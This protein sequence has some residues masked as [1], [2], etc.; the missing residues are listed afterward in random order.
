MRKKMNCMFSIVLLL[1]NMLPFL[2]LSAR[3]DDLKIGVA[4]VKITPPLGIPLAGQYFD[5]GATAVHDDLF[6]KALVIET[7]G[8]KVAIVT[9]D[10]VDIGTDLVPAVRKMA[11]KSTGIPGDHIMISATHSHTG[12]VIPSPGNINSSQGPIPDILTAYIEKLP[13]LICESIKQ[14]NKNLRS[15]R[16]SGGLGHE[17]TISF[18]RRFY[19]TDGTVGWNPGKLNP[20]IIKPAGPIDPDVSVLYAETFDGTPLLTFVNFALHLDIAGGL[21]ISADMPYTLSKILGAVKNPSMITMFSQG[22]CGNINH[23]NVKTG[24][25]QSGPAEAERIGTVLAGEVIRTCTMLRPIRIDN[26]SV[27]SEIVPLPTAPVS[28]EELPWARKIAARYGKPDAAPFMDMVK[29]FKIIEITDRKGKPIEAEI[30]IMAL[31]DSCAIVSLPGEIF[32]ELGMYIKSRSPYPFTI[33]EE[34]ANTS[35]DYIPDMKAYM[36]GNYE[37]VSSR[38]APGSGELLAEKAIEMLWKLKHQ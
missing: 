20:M 13:G 24:G 11:A 28:A 34:L 22:C 36:E 12:P 37:P 16:I 33:I 30:Q 23:I 27:R 8:V 15:G 5:R 21:E 19:M 29:A 25:E 2:F 1:I 3:A 6:A 35:V 4:A 10:L 32:T 26:I 17:E 7:G 18:N 31:G 14:A 38:C 9:C